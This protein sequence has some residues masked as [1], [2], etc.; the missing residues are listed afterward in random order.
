MVLLSDNQTFET[1]VQEHVTLAIANTVD[2]LAFILVNDSPFL[3]VIKG[4]ANFKP[5]VVSSRSTNALTLCHARA[6]LVFANRDSERVRGTSNE[7]NDH[8]ETNPESYLTSLVIQ[9]RAADIWLC[10]KDFHRTLA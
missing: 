10:M 4:L 7:D 6:L 5:R 2:E 9:P 8:K 1:Y 3:G